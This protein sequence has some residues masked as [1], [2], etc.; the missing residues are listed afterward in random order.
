MALGW[1]WCWEGN[2]GRGADQMV[3]VLMTEVVRELLYKREDDK[4][5]SH[6]M[7]NKK[8]FLGFNSSC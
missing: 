1:E 5:V 8:N 6:S 2:I 4:G 3:K 7:I